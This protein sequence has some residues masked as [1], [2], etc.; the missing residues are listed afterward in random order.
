MPKAI[1]RDEETVER[2]FGLLEHSPGAIFIKDAQGRYTYVSASFTALAG[3]AKEEIIG[4]SDFDLFPRELA[5]S[6]AAEDDSVR[7][8]RQPMR[9]EEQFSYQGQQLSFLT[10]KFLLPSGEVASIALDLTKQKEVEQELR[11]SEERLLLATEGSGLGTY[12][13]DLATGV[14]TWSKRAFEVLGLQPSPS[15]TA[16]FSDWNERVHP[17]DKE[18]LARQHAEA[19]GRG[20]PWQATYRV[21]RAD[22]GETRWLRC[23]GAFPTARSGSRRSIGVVADVTE[24]VLAEEA[25]RAAEAVALEQQLQ[26]ITLANVVPAFVWFASPDGKLNFLNERWYEY[27]G[28]TPE[29]ALPD[30]WAL[31]LHQED[32]VLTGEVWSSALAN[33]TSYEVE[34]R[35]RR[36][37]GAYRWYIARA[38]PQRD[39]NGQ[40]LRWF[41]TSTD[42][43]ER[44]VAEQKLRE[45]NQDLEA[46]IEQRTAERDRMWRASRDLLCVARTDGTLLS[47]NPAWERKLGWSEEDLVGRV[48]AEIKH[49]DDE[50]RTQAGLAQLAAGMPIDGF[51]DR[52]RHRDGSWRWISWSIEPAGEL[53]YCAGRDV[54]A[55]KERAKELA[56]LEAARRKAD[57][58]YRAYFE[59]TAEALFV[60]NVLEDGGFAIEDLNPAHQ[61]S[62]GLPLAQVQ[63]KRIDSVLPAVLAEPV[64][65][66]YRAAI[67]SDGVHQYREF[68]E[69]HGRRTFWDTVLVP[70]RDE[71]G[72]TVR[73]IGSSRD[74]TNQIAA[75]EQ[76]RQSQKMEAMG[77]LTGGVAHDFNN[78]LTPIIGALDMLQRQG[79]GGEREQRLIE[80]AAQSAERARTLVQRL[81]AFAR[82]QPLQPTPV[83]VGQLVQ[84]MADLI[85]STIGPQIKVTVEV[86][87]DLPPARADP[88]QLEMALLNLAVNARDAMPDGGRLRISADAAT[89]GPNHQSGLQPGRYLHLS[90]A[91]NG[92]GMD[93]ATRARAVEPFFSTKGIGRGTGLGL[94]MVH[95]LALQLGG[96]LT[97]RS[98]PGVGTN[99]ELWLPESERAQLD[100]AAAPQVSV[101]R[102]KG[103]VLLVDDEDLVRASTSDMLNDLGYAVQEACSA[104]E[105]LRLLASGYEP[106]VIVTD[107]LMPG[108]S[109]ADLARKVREVHPQSKVL[110]ISGY[111]DVEGIA[112]DLPRLTKPFRIKDLAQSLSEL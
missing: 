70:V 21:V 8:S 26:L 39:A 27:T 94:S 44:K 5:N 40:I 10:H 6:F 86:A 106:E 103:K 12:D 18:E 98:T 17:D 60:V 104:E 72:T 93:E 50:E 68:F 88:N 42:I 14:G 20:G 77:Q 62:I 19:E 79:L 38:E 30:G 91:D 101:P 58:L 36:H 75:E 82:R 3:R 96:A 69:L 80:G 109:G 107:H 7:S 65:E 59:N 31:T 84:G 52:Y 83:D 61:S 55:E 67:A 85:V 78:L 15:G 48:A 76:L 4:K 92:I 35:Y 49:P 37:D 13:L 46:S 74:L 51:E 24:V 54:T 105:A 112:V 56:I 66:H 11:L 32:A 29:E 23:H 45:L 25:A 71:R 108:M 87:E 63:G 34:C 97:I 9:F 99:I 47:V 28:Q 57:A 73:L 16:S 102:G 41:G 33:G 43:H 64:I 53:I 22:N 1:V 95:G 100:A 90:I 89:V 81:L 2:L 110:L 111:A